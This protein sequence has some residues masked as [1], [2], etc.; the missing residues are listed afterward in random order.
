MKTFKSFIDSQEDKHFVPNE[1]VHFKHGNSNESPDEPFV[2]NEPVHYKNDSHIE[3]ETL[4]EAKKVN[5]LDKNDNEEHYDNI[6][7]PRKLSTYLVDNG[8]KHTPKESE[9]IRDYTVDSRP[10]N[11]HL[12]ARHKDPTLKPVKGLDSLYDDHAS[13]IKHLDSATSHKLNHPLHVY[14]GIRWDPSEQMKKTDKVHLPAYTSATHDKKMAKGYAHEHILHIHLKKGDKA[15]H[16]SHLSYYKKE[17][18]TILPRNTTLKVNK[19]PTKVVHGKK[20]YHVWHATVHSQ[21]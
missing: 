4:T 2:P 9:A 14:S 3:E 17:H 19:T 8:K 18:E 13:M 12:V 5:W 15:A 10:L 20:T 1:P 21:K 16:V 6:E 11:R 7:T